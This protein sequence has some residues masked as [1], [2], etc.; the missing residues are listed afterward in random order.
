MLI[1]SKEAYENTMNGG[2]KVVHEKE[3]DVKKPA[4]EYV[5]LVEVLERTVPFEEFEE[6]IRAALDECCQVYAHNS[7]MRP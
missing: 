7:L 4:A 3:V 6:V 1:R 2:R 5:T